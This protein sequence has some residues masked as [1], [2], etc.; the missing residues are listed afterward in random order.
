MIHIPTLEPRCNSWVVSRKNGEVVG[1]FYERRN[2]EKFNPET[3][4]V[5]TA[6]TYLGRAN[7]AIVSA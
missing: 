1:E 4:I 2:V 3:C 6:L 5:E 7:Q